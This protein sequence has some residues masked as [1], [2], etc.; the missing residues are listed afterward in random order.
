MNVTGIN[1]A[2]A[3]IPLPEQPRKD[4]KSNAASG[5]ARKDR[6]ELSKDSRSKD[7]TS[8]GIAA[9]AAAG[10]PTREDKIQEVRRKLDE[11]Y[12]DQPEVIEKTAQK[13]IDKKLV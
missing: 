6:V 8:A 5:S 4:G 10:E 7:S 3:P 12:Y 9:V 11:G 13:L 2:G 1:F